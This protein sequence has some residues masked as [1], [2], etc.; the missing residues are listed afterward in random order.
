MVGWLI[1]C[2]KSGGDL[3]G[4]LGWWQY[5]E[6]PIL[7]C[8]ACR[9]IMDEVTVEGCLHE[10][11]QLLLSFGIEFLYG[12]V[13][14]FLH[15]FRLSRLIRQNQPYDPR[16]PQKCQA[17]HSHVDIVTRVHSCTG[18]DLILARSDVCSECDC[19]G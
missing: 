12:N 6:N 7:V 16:I 11:T 15:V 4:S 9:E 18:I 5:N 10:E 1:D 19:D 8:V 17:F 13:R 3:E 2:A 14:P